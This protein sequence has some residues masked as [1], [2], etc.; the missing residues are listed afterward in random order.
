[1]L[2]TTS[3]LRDLLADFQKLL[4]EQPG[5]APLRRSP[6]QQREK[7]RKLVDEWLNQLVGMEVDV[8]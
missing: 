8:P 1:M 5:A 3:H 4:G 2:E 7:I 6:A